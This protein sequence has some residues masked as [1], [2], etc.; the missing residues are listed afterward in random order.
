MTTMSS[1]AVLRGRATA[2]E[3]ALDRVR[4]RLVR[5]LPDDRFWGW[6]LPLAIAL[7]AGVL[8]LWRITRPPGPELKRAGGLIFDETYY[9]HDSWSLLHHGVE[10]NS[11]DSGPGFVVHPPLGKWMI[12]LGQLLFGRGDTVVIDGH[13]YAA[14]TLSFRVAAAVVGTLSVLMLARIAR[15]LFRS[16]LLG[17]VAGLLLT[18]EGL[19]FVQ[20]RVA[21]LDIFLMFWVLAAFG[22]LLLD[23]D[24][25]RQRLASLLE[26]PIG[27]GGRGP[28]LGFRPFRWAAAVCLGAATAT[29]WDG[30]FWLP[31]FMLLAA[32]WDVGA[33]R[34]AGYEHPVRDAARRDWLPAVV[35][36][37]LVVVLVYAVSWAGWFLSDGTHAYNHDKYVE[38]GQSWFGHDLAVLHGWWD[39]H[40]Q[41]YDF[42]NGLDSGHPYLSRPWG[43]LLLSRPVAYFYASP[44]T[45]GAASCAQEVL[46]VGTPAIWWAAIFALVVV[47]WRAIGR[48]DWRAGAIGLSFL[49]GY[50]PWFY[51][52]HE[53]RTMFLFY[54]LPAVP[55]MVLAVTYVVG[56]VVGGPR[57]SPTRRTAGSIVAGAYLLAVLAN[58]AFLYPVLSGKVVT[59][60]QWRLRMQPID[61]SCGAPDDRNEQHELAGCWI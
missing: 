30:L 44:K 55:F 61:W 6:L 27:P 54:M 4:G 41:I 57:S 16:T 15:R 37:A 51:A 56:M 47:L 38:A 58:F 9:A 7:G 29:K 40:R 43:W 48:L 33:R 2:E 25:G 53:H 8:R 10:L 36:F 24:Q 59:Y 1:T 17:C 19:E 45:C 60:D 39:Y 50:L 13:H 18:L 22:C 21:M 3:E 5:P 14:S 23:R 26:R 52:D 46:G 32:V 34:T 31:A 35:P 42:H 28:S 49:V 11:S 20:S 12:A